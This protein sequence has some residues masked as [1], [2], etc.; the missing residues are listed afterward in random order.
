[1]PTDFAIRPATDGD[2]PGILAVLRAALGETPILAR[3]HDLWRWKHH[4][5]PFGE[6]LVLVATAGERIVGVR[7]MMRWTLTTPD[8]ATLRCLRPVDTATHPDFHRRGVFRKLTMTAVDLA[9]SQGIDLIFN[10]PNRRSG[11]GYLSLGWRRVGRVGVMVRPR[12]GRVPT[13]PGPIPDVDRYLP[14]A[15]PPRPVE[16]I[17]SGRGLRTPRTPE[18][19]RWRFGSHPTVRYRTVTTGETTAVVRVNLRGGR[20]ELV[21]SDLLGVPE[22]GPIRWITRNHLARY[23]AGWFAPGSPERTAALRAGML[24]IPGVTALELFALPLTPGLGISDLGDWDLATS[25][26]ELL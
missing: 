6:S 8:G 13:E 16:N 11:P 21:L 25:D 19:Q 24:P 23:V 2:V 18:Y 14:G 26:L 3:T 12:A 7:A 10:T 5:N 9:R 20:P 4:D 15:S 22:P 17:R 1:M